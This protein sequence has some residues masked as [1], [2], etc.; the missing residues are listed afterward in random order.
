[1]LPALAVAEAL[2][3]RGARVSFAG[4]PD[5][6]EAQLVAEAGYEFDP[7]ESAGLPRRPGLQL[8]RALV[9]AARAPAACLKIL[10]RRRPDVVLGGGGYVSGP[11]VLAAALRR[12][13]TGL[14]EADAHLGLAN[15]LAAPLVD[16]VFLAVPIP[17]RDGAKYRVSGRPVP[18]RSRT[19]PPADARRRFELPP[20]SPVLLVLGG[21]QGS[22]RLNE[23]AVTHWS[24][25]GPV[26]LHICG[27]RDYPALRGRVSRS[28]YRLLA[29]TDEIGAAYSAAD[30]ALARA[31]GSVWE[32]AAAGLPAVL[33]PYPYATADHQTKNA[34]HFE[35]AGGAV[36]VPEAELERVPAIVDELLRDGP[37][38]DRMRDAMLRI[39][40]ADAADEIA[41]ELVTLGSA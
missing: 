31:G 12:I 14:L 15:R 26:V 13:P 29:F 11:M 33:V 20:D 8:A 17:G 21:S 10:S 27:R 38:R 28:G 5:R 36:V 9:T 32:L 6:I 3:A 18:R 25:S 30:L 39:A 34:R 40:R 24:A 41:E 22:L 2:Q 23:L 7:F 37:R 1:M 19:V 35:A 4:L 16:R